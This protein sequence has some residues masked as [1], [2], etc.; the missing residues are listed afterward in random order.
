MNAIDQAA[1]HVARSEDVCQASDAHE[2]IDL[3]TA[4]PIQYPW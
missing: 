2:W 3:N 1:S 4:V